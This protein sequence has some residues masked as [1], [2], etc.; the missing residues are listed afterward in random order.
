ML[1]LLSMKASPIKLA[2]Y[3]QN[4]LM[5]TDVKSTWKKRSVRLKIDSFIGIFEMEEVKCG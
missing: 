4:R 1:F 2:F 5:L 3:V